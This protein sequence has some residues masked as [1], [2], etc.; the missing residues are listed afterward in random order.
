[1]KCAVL[2][3]VTLLLLGLVVD[4]YVI[5]PV[6]LHTVGKAKPKTR[7]WKPTRAHAFG[8]TSAAVRLSTSP[9]SCHA[10]NSCRYVT[11]YTADDGSSW[12]VME[13]YHDYCGSA[14]VFQNN[15]LHC[16]AGQI[17]DD[18]NDT[19]VTYRQV[20]YTIKTAGLISSA[21]MDRHELET[22][23]TYANPSEDVVIKSIRAT[24]ETTPYFEDKGLYFR[25][26]ALEL[27]NGT[28]VHALYRSTD[29]HN[30]EFVS[31]VPFPFGEE[32]AIF[33]WGE[34]K[35]YIIAGRPGNYTQAESIYLGLRW[36]KVAESKFSTLMSS[37]VSPYYTSIYTGIR[38]RPGIFAAAQGSK[39]GSEKPINVV[40][41]HNR[42]VRKIADGLAPEDAT[43]F[44]EEYKNGTHGEV[45]CHL[46]P[47]PVEGC[48]SSSYATLASTQ[49]GTVFIFY[50]KLH[51]G[52]REAT[53]EATSTV[54]ALKLSLNE[55]KEQKDYEDRVAAEK[56]R[57]EQE[58]IQ[59]EARRKAEKEAEE[60]RK[61]ERREKRRK[62][63]ERRAA[64][65][66]IDA[67]YVDRA[68]EYM[69]QDDEL[70]VVREVDSKWIDLEKDMYV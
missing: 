32:S 59:E 63:K 7:L 47:H 33:R 46:D 23:S 58:K 44:T 22:P 10:D 36:E 34:T 48:E 21:S 8:P 27:E 40:D 62:D 1:M 5:K 29:G 49:N 68:R 18:N 35:L 24:G 55:T 6:S 4:A 37:Y 17:V 25:N 70:V 69:Q 31:Y 66:N 3:L 41:Q 51:N 45:D 53:E 38:G 15:I 61:R 67:A 52:F 28:E 20:A 11:S 60:R 12:T 13:E 14:G 65:R 30:W 9:E 64:Y 54:H 2:A 26:L 43:N 57:K 50:D 56:K 42:M 19:V 39:K 16:M